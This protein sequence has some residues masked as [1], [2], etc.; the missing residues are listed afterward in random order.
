MSRAV[1]PAVRERRALNLSGSM[2]DRER[3]RGTVLA[4]GCRG[5]G[6]GRSQC[7]NFPVMLCHRLRAASSSARAAFR[8][9]SCWWSVVIWV[10]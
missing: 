2:A 10:R 9:R 1:P 7:G 3:L 5:H 6:A 4:A 8:W